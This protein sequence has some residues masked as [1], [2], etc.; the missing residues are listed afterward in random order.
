MNDFRMKHLYILILMLVV[1]VPTRMLASGFGI[2]SSEIKGSGIT[3]KSSRFNEAVAINFYKTSSGLGSFEYY[4]I[5]HNRPFYY[6]YGFFMDIPENGFDMSGGSEAGFKL[7]DQIDFL[8]PM[9]LTTLV[10][11]K[12]EIYADVTMIVN[13]KDLSKIG[14]DSSFGIRVFP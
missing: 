14:M 11:K 10:Q 9:G 6:G 2:H 4:N 5:H 8:F 3:Y 7:L 13:S 12:F 1:S